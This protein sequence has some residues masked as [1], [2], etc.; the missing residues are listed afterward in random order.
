MQYSGDFIC[1]QLWR[2]FFACDYPNMTYKDCYHKGQHI[3]WGIMSYTEKEARHTSK[4]F[5]HDPQRSFLFSKL[6]MNFI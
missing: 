1:G 6:F 3:L 5:Q 2:D 4:Y